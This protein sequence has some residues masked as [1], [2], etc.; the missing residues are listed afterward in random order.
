MS[1]LLPPVT[2]VEVSTSALHHN[3]A[4]LRQAARVGGRSPRLCVMVKGNAYG[5]GMIPAAR[6]LL[7]A[8]VDWLGTHDLFEIAALREAGITAPIYNVGYL[9]PAQMPAAVA[10]GAR[11]VVYDHDVLRAA[12]AAAV[13]TG[14]LA[15]LH[16]KLETGNNRQGLRQAQAVAFAQEAATL[17]GIEIEGLC[18]HF[19]DIE[20][21]T[22][23]TFAHSQLVRFH[24]IADAVR[25]VLHLPARGAP[26]DRLLEHCANTAALLLW[27]EVC[28]SMVRFGIGAYG[29]WPSK[30]TWL[31][32]CELGQKPVELRPALT[33][34]AQIAQV[35]E[36]PKG[37]YIG[38]GRTFRTV[39]DSQIAILPVGY[40]DGYDRGLSG[41]GK[42]LVSG[43]R[44]PVVGR[45]AMNM[46]AVDVTD[47]GSA[48]E[49]VRA[50]QE[51]VLLGRQ[52]AADG[53]WE[54]ISA[55]ELASW[56]GTIHYEIT[57]RINDRILRRMVT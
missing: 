12:S 39:R 13:A 42:V 1:L 50:G 25:S 47:A 29:L 56:A 9:S 24:A 27:P 52:Q 5:H 15:R 2:W 53:S 8:G 32:V 3:I 51:V 37:E 28:G 20:D 14:Q 26:D 40:Y 7:A 54:S 57:T 19:A 17:P 41:I 23:H 38:Y 11:F 10:L 30:E 43:Q 31:S 48:Q 44:A 18:T 35:R 55:D 34:K 33:W 6:E 4:V 36:V 16:I 21:T 49:P 22:N 45:V 46:I